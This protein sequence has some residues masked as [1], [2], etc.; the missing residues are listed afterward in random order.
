MTE[1]NK[2]FHTLNNEFSACAFINS[3]PKE[4]NRKNLREHLTYL[5]GFKDTSSQI[6]ELSYFYYSIDKKYS[7]SDYDI[8]AEIILFDIISTLV[9]K[10]SGIFKY[11]TLDNDELALADEIIDYICTI[12]NLKDSFFN[13]LLMPQE[14]F[15]NMYLLFKKF[16]IGEDLERSINQ[17]YLNILKNTLNNPVFKL[18]EARPE[19]I[20]FVVEDALDMIIKN[21]LNMNYDSI[22][23]F[24]DCFVIED[25]EMYD[26]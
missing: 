8:D 12:G 23:N 14:S 20:K 15:H 16:D 5:R 22:E 3:L 2:K 6:K 9:N 18:S 25:L 26:F 21:H 1:E 17:R 7:K 11:G 10:V 13:R 24:K 19:T 4:F